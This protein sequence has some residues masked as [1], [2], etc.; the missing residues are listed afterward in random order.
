MFI[1]SV[2]SSLQAF[3]YFTLH[4]IMNFS[5][6]EQGFLG[7]QE[8]YDIL[9]SF[10]SCFLH[11]R[12]SAS[13]VKTALLSLNIN[14][15]KKKNLCGYCTKSEDKKGNTIKNLK[16]K[17]AVIKNHKQTAKHSL[18]FVIFSGQKCIIHTFLW[19]L[20]F[21][22]YLSHLLWMACVLFS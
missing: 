2:A 4:C 7:E 22:K 5:W 9:I 12:R 10:S 20:E 18:L 6:C 14:K 13:K 17:V 16:Q 15:K 8:I 1:T 3:P 19:I 21:K 11:F